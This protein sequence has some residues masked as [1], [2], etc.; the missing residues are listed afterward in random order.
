[1]RVGLRPRR[2]MGTVVMA[3]GEG[4]RV[5]GGEGSVTNIKTVPVLVVL[6]RLR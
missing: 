5:D 3:T 4:R 2:K 6:L 1:M